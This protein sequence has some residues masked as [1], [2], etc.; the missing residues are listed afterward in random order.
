M[1]P[2]AVKARQSRERARAAGRPLPA[3]VD[4]ALIQAISAVLIDLGYIHG[5]HHKGVF[6]QRFRLCD[7]LRETIRIL[8][9]RQAEDGS[10]RYEKRQMFQAIMERMRVTERHR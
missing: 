9:Q 2:D 10:P 5:I 3:D 4:R 6:S 7:I 8:R 1:H